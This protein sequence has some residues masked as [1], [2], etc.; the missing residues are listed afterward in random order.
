MNIEQAIEIRKIKATMGRGRPL[1]LDQVFRVQTI[2]PPEKSAMLQ[3]SVDLAVARLESG[4]RLTRDYRAAFEKIAPDVA[5]RYFTPETKK[6]APKSTAERVS[7]YVARQSDIGECPACLRPDRRDSCRDDLVRFGVTYCGMLLQHAPS[8]RMC[9]FIMAMQRTLLHG[10]KVHVRWPRG[11]GKTTWTRIALLW[12][13]SYGHRRFMVVINATGEDA[14]ATVAEITNVIDRS[15]EYAADFPEVS[16]PVRALEGV[17]QRCATQNIG[18]IRTKIEMTAKTF[19]FPTVEGSA[20]SGVRIHARGIKGSLRGMIVNQTR[21]DFVFID[22]AQTRAAATSRSETNKFMSVISGDIDGL[23][24]HNRK[25]ATVIASTPVAPG[26]GSSRLADPDQSNGLYTITVPLVIHWPNNL[27]LWDEWTA[28]YRAEKMIGDDLHAESREYYRTHRAEMDDG[29]VVID[30]ADGDPETEESAIHHAFVRRADIGE[31]AFNAEYQMLVEKDAALFELTPEFVRGRVNG[32]PRCR[33]PIACNECVAYCDVNAEAGMRWGVL[34]CG[35]GNVAALVAYGRYP[36]TGRLYPETA[37]ETQIAQA[38]AAGMMAVVQRV[39][40]LPLYRNNERKRP[41]ALV[42]DGGWQTRTVGAFVQTV[43]APFKLAWSKGF[44]CRSYRPRDNVAPIGDH[45]HL[46][47]SE[48][49]TFM[50]ICADY[51]REYAQRALLGHPLT[52]GSIS[53]YG[54]PNEHALLAE[55]MCAETLIDKT[56]NASGMDVWTWDKH[57]ENH[58]GD[59]VSSLCAVA[60]WY[61]LLQPADTLVAPALAELIHTAV[62]VTG[63]TPA[64]AAPTPRRVKITAEPHRRRFHQSFVAGPR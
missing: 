47:H 30:P 14:K 22:D 26:D 45:C 16:H 34:A 4:G 41:Y 40:A 28:M 19:V 8:E 39:A 51:W 60:S 10:G 58:Y 31:T 64:T 17:V 21:P 33:I 20:A 27:A 42:F 36:E 52:T 59:V 32:F 54:E 53:W 24:G 5:A 29:C 1:S 6:A 49:G 18:G 15:D 44:G 55:E 56:K 63:E 61:H 11:K 23:A 48:N 37:N 2:N 7:E 57:G 62:P 13:A 25:M 3:K 43:N 9:E 50:A 12:A 38:V 35:R 46:S